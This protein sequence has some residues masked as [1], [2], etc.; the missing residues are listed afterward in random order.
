[1]KMIR[2]NGT[3]RM[4][5]EAQKPF[6]ESNSLIM[7]FC[8]LF[9]FILV[10]FLLVSSSILFILLFLKPRKPI[11]HLHSIHLDS[12][13]L[14]TSSGK[15]VYL[16]ASTASLLFV[17]QNFN[18]FGIRYSPSNFGMIYESNPVGVVKVP[19]F[20]QPPNGTNVTVIMHVMLE[21]VNISRFINAKTG[22]NRGNSSEGNQIE[23]QIVGIVRARIHVINFSF[24]MMKFSLDCSIKVDYGAETFSKGAMFMKTHKV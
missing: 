1:M 10:S 22:N 6:K 12:I 20:Y 21:R 16:Q 17:A 23:V 19:G 3:N 24:P 11:F 13:K 4:D 8:C 15:G 9:S 7:R 2:R 5:S 14:D 18:K